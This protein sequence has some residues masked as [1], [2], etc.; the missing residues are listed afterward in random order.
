M[1]VSSYIYSRLVWRSKSYIMQV[2]TWKRF[3]LAC[4]TLV[5]IA[6]RRAVL[7]I[8]VAECPSHIRMVCDSLVPRGSSPWSETSAVE[9]SFYGCGPKI[10]LHILGASR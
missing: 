4:T 3:K 6:L 10:M 7:D 9:I 8:P 2:L 5:V 1:K